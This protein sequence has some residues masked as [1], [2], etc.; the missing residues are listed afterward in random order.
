MD[1]ISNNLRLQPCWI[2]N[3]SLESYGGVEG[4]EKELSR[5]NIRAVRIFP[6]DHVYALA[7]WMM[8]DLL[9][10]LDRRKS[11]VFMDLDQVFL[12]TGMYDYDANG[13]ER[14]ERLCSPNLS[15]LTR[16]GYRIPEPDFKNVQSHLDLSFL[17][18][19]G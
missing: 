18:P 1:E 8:G 19:P 10:L 15:R 13:C 11:V 4:L 3:P 12:Q 7:E 14:V 16:L 17:H 9:S 5:Q 6:K 2:L